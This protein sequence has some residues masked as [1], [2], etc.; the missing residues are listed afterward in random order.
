[1]SGDAHG[2]VV[3]LYHGPVGSYKARTLAV[4]LDIVHR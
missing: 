3:D 1:M 2:E 4:A